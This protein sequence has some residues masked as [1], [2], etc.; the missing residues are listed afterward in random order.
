MLYAGEGK[1]DSAFLWFDRVAKW[2]IQPMVS[3][4]ADRRLAPVRGDS[5]YRQLLTKLGIR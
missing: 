4:Q 5:R 2:G 3:L 1:L